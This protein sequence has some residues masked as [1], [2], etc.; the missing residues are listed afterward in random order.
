[1]EIECKL[2][3]SKNVVVVVRAYVVNIVKSASKTH[4]S[5]TEYFVV[6]FI[7]SPQQMLKDVSITMDFNNTED[8]ITFIFIITSV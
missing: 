3:V 5:N 6:F 4:L 7:F 2:I 1:M 8:S